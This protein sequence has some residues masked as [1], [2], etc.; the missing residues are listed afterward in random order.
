MNPE[1]T[2]KIRIRF[3]AEADAAPAATPVP[4]GENLTCPSFG[5]PS[6]LWCGDSEIRQSIMEVSERI[7]ESKPH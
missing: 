5:A 6:T 1:T 2:N 3:L 4:I 7:S